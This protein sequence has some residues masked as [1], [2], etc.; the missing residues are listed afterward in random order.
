MH[1]IT[2]IAK[3]M[4]PDLVI[5]DLDYIKHDQQ[6]VQDAIEIWKK[7]NCQVLIY[8]LDNFVNDSVHIENITSFTKWIW[9]TNTEAQ[10]FTKAY[11][12]DSAH[13]APSSLSGCFAH[14]YM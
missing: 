13:A 2:D 9:K 10:F 12:S 5:C 14:T 4:Y 8:S 11:S 6:L 3:E 7:D 1:S